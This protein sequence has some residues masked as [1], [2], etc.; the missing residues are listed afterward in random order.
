MK[1]E[2]KYSYGWTVKRGEYGRGGGLIYFLQQEAGSH[3]SDRTL[4]ERQIK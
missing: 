4:G 3:R 2:I 1:Q